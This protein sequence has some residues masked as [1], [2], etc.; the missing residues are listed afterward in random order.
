[1]GHIFVEQV[2]LINSL[3]AFFK[4]HCYAICLGEDYEYG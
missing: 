3:S 2:V 1:M 4:S